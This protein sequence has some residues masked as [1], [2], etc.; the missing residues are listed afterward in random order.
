[1][2]LHRL[3]AV[4]A[5]HSHTFGQLIKGTDDLLIQDGQVM[6]EKMRRNK[7]TRRDLLE[8]LRLNGKVSSPEEVKEAHYERSGD[9]SVVKK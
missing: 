3:L 7:L 6:E 5:F 4:I 2:L 9:I 8:E 1:M